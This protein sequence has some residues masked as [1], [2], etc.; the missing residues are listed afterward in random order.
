MATI[1]YFKDSKIPLSI[2]DISDEVFSLLR[3]GVLHEQIIAID[4]FDANNEES[5]RD[6]LPEVIFRHQDDWFLAAFCYLRD[7]KR[8]FRID[9]IESAELTERHD[10]SHGVADDIRKN[11]L[12]WFNENISAGRGY[13]VMDNYPTDGTWSKV[14]LVPGENEP[15]LQVLNNLLDHAYIQSASNFRWDFSQCARNNNLQEMRGNI[16]A[17]ADVNY[18]SGDGS[19][20]IHSAARYG[21]FE[22][23]EYLIKHGADPLAR[24]G[25]GNTPLMAASCGGNLKL[26]KYLLEEKNSDIHAKN[27]SGW[28]PLYWAVLDAHIEIIQ[29]YLAS[30][31]D[32]NVRTRDK[33]TV[34]MLAVGRSFASDDESIA[35]ARI[36][37][38]AGAELNAQDKSGNSVL[39]HAIKRDNPTVMDFLLESGASCSLFDRK[40]N[41]PLLRVLQNFNASSRYHSDYSNSQHASAED[42]L[43]TLVRSLVSHRVDVNAGNREGITALMLA[44]LSVMRYLVSYGA[45]VRAKTN[46]GKTVAMFHAGDIR[47]LRF[48]AECGADITERDQ[49]GDSVL[50]LAPASYR[51][52]RYLIEKYGFSVNEKNH[53]NETILH[54]ACEASDLRLVQYLVDHK[55]NINVKDAQGKTPL[56]YIEERSH[57]Y[58]SGD[59]DDEIIDIL[60]ACP[61]QC[62]KIFKMEVPME[63]YFE[64][65]PL[66][67]PN[68]QSRNILKVVIDLAAEPSSIGYEAEKELLRKKEAVVYDGEDYSAPDWKCVACGSYFYKVESPPIRYVF[69]HKPAE[70][71]VCHSQRIAEVLYGEP[72]YNEE[73]LR[74]EK[75]GEVIIGGCLVSADYP[76]WQCYNCKQDLHKTRW[77]REY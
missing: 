46:T 39:I 77:F 18:R 5:K 31:A 9:R 7:E 22:A 45:N 24:D 25:D 66:E 32:V 70:C 2:P 28:T 43:A 40:G 23:V 26:V 29:Y 42:V 37:I 69:D 8:T 12:Q 50:L 72:C 33:E 6:V 60:K 30:G 71:P 61:K 51:L 16:A 36:L 13:E 48:L 62:E 19:M 4:Y 55:V 74:Q 38:E 57:C 59:N 58:D 15:E 20:P 49:Y 65:K 64:H 14:Q 76:D 52:T 47:T 1:Y 44:G 53:R 10:Q 73:L 67:C 56:D 11:G 54:H 41:T 63:K 35:I 21:S 68:C 3:S 75:N 17:G 27:L 34:L